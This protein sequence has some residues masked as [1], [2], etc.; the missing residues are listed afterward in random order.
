MLKRNKIFIGVLLATV[1]YC[2]VGYRSLFADTTS[3]NK[4]STYV[5]MT[6]DSKNVGLFSSEGM[7]SEAVPDSNVYRA[8]NVLAP[9]T[10]LNKEKGEL[11]SDDFNYVKDDINLVLDNVT[12]LTGLENLNGHIK[13]VTITNSSIDSIKPLFQ[14]GNTV[15]KLTIKGNK[16]VI[17]DYYLLSEGTNLKYLDIQ[18]TGEEMID[19]EDFEPITKL[20]HLAVLKLDNLGITDLTGI[21]NLTDLEVLYLKDSS[22]RKGLFEDVFDSSKFKNLK[23]LVLDDNNIQTF[24]KLKGFTTLNKLEVSNQKFLDVANTDDLIYIIKQ[25]KNMKEVVLRN[26]VLSDKD[27][28]KNNKDVLSDSIKFTIENKSFNYDVNNLPVFDIGL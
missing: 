6:Y 23:E 26:L 8:M 10:D 21:D 11:H 24:E 12:D 9:E 4:N 16:T 27:F 15:E 17:K 2:G 18:G 20:N 3:I 19:Y 28:V 1:V 5:D 14:K 13:S 22:F 7:H 25:N